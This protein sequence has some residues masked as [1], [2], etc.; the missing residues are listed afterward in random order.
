VYTYFRV[1]SISFKIYNRQTN[2]QFRYALEARP[3][4]NAQASAIAQNAIMNITKVTSTMATSADIIGKIKSNPF[5]LR[6]HF[7]MQVSLADTQ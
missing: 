4:K 2:K 6:S 1:N 3:S 5:S 7:K